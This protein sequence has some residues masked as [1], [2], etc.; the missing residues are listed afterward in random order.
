MVNFFK[1]KRKKN[2]FTTM[3]EMIEISKGSEAPEALPE[4]LDLHAET[5][6]QI[7]VIKDYYSVFTPINS[8]D[9]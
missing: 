2:L 4:S 1:S 6:T 7:G 9:G 8:I 3:T 5:P